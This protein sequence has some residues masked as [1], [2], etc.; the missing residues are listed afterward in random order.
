MDDVAARAGVSRAT[1]SRVLSGRAK[2]SAHTRQ[3]VLS[4][5]NELGYVPNLAASQLAGAPSPLVGLLLRD[6]RVPAYGL[7]HSALQQHTYEV[8]LQ[9]VTAVPSV[10]QAAQYEELSLQRLIGLRVAGLFVSTGVI[11]SESLL[12]FISVV[13][14]VSVGRAEP[15]P[16]INAVSYDEVGHAA[17]LADAV[18]A[19]GHAHVAVVVPTKDVSIVESLR[20]QAIIQR[21]SERGVATKRVD[22]SEFGV[23]GG[24]EQQV[25]RL[26]RRRSI[27]AVMFTSDVRALQ[28]MGVAA[29]ADIRIPQD[30]SVTGCDG[31]LP[32][33]QQIGLCTVRLPVETVARRA[34]DVMIQLVETPPGERGSARQELH[35]GVLLPG[36]SLGIPSHS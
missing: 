1:V 13:P 26:V 23:T 6:P 15:H 3:S 20:G 8:G 27:T 17:L 25:V 14:V 33:V 31:I 7:L 16:D 2:V 34:S 21:L 30:I 32:G 12:P 22:V 11:P 35:T 9:L 36:R 29:S 18:I 28:F 19:H 5:I 4:A 10:T 24:G